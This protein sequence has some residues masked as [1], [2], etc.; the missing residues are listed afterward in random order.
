MDDANDPKREPAPIPRPEDVRRMV[1]FAAV[2]LPRDQVLT[3][4]VAIYLDALAS[5]ATRD[6]I[7]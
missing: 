4:A 5:S 3:R 2:V 7:H 1:A 6:G